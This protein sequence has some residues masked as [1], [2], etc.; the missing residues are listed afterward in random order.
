MLTFSHPGFRIQG[1]KRHPIPD[2][3]SGSASLCT[4]PYSL[5]NRQV[6]GP[7][8]PEKETKTTSS[9]F[10]QTSIITVRGLLGKFLTFLTPIQ[11]DCFLPSREHSKWSVGMWKKV[12]CQIVWEKTHLSLLPVLGNLRTPEWKLQ[13]SVW[14]GWYAVRGVDL[15]HLLVNTPWHKQSSLFVLWMKSFIIE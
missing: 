4:V 7:Y 1:S 11:S 12:L 14:R 15:L 6:F 8:R 3:G 10:K 5:K 2:P 13:N 9:N